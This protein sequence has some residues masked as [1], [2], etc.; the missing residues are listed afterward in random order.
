MSATRQ[1]LYVVRQWL[2]AAE[3]E[4]EPGAG[5]IMKPDVREALRRIVDSI[6]V[7]DAVAEGAGDNQ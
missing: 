5:R 3:R 2:R 7:S 4:S 6:V 1:D